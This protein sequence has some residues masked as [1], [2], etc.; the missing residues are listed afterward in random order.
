MGNCTQLL[1]PLHEWITFPFPSGGT[2]RGRRVKSV[3]G[4]GERLRA[5]YRGM[6]CRFPFSSCLQVLLLAV[7]GV[8]CC[9]ED[10]VLLQFEK[11]GALLPPVAIALYEA[12]APRHAANFKRLVET[13][14]YKQ[15]SI[16]RF[17]AGRL[18]Q[19]GDPFSRSKD[20]PDIGTGGPGYTVAPEIGRAH[21]EGS[22]AMGRLPDRINP[23][24]LSNGS[25]F[26]VALKALPELDGT[27]TVF[28]R[29][30]RGLEVLAGM[31]EAAVDTNEVPVERVVL[32]RARLVPREG[33]ERELAA[34]SES[35]KKGPSWW[36][37]NRGKLWPF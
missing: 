2:A 31:S 18:V 5:I 14:F 11:K 16:H 13:G 23:S 9:A 26:Y 15:T 19:L 7:S 6:R 34:W 4:L 33:L 12:D 28:G 17:A 24:R 36:G 22:V 3:S 32:R 37:R 21:A 25:Q 35:A 8:F 10:V 1:H 29:V 30:E 20:S 27:D